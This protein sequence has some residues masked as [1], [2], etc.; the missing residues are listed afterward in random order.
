MGR[1]VKAEFRKILTTKMWWAL[2]IPA[3]LLTV[4][5]GWGVSALVTSIVEDL[6]NT[7]LLE[8]ADVN[9][10]EMSWSI[11]ALTRSMNIATVFPMVFGALALASEISR[12]TITT[13]FLTAPNRASVLTAKAITYVLW[14]AIYGVVVA[15]GA[16]IGMLIGSKES[17]LPSAGD[18]ILVLLAGIVACIL[19][20]LLGMGVG[21]LLGSPVATVILLLVYALVVGPFGELILAG[22]T[23]NNHVIGFLPNGSANGLTGSTASALL[24]GQVQDLVA[25]SQVISQDAVESFD[26]AVRFAAGAPGAF[27]L[28]VSGIIFVAWTMVFFVTGLLRNQRRDIT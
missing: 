24:F 8:Q 1:L 20:T 4:G 6:S 18:W 22:L 9:L 14:G 11:I 27:S 3:V 19:W 12:K 15:I 25:G 13:S 7:D 26:E 23:D 16:S 21:A 5:W 17:L 28:L 10:D 2:L